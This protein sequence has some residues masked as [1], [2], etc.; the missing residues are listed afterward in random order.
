MQEGGVAYSLDKAEASPHDDAP[1]PN[2]LH[3]H[4]PQKPGMA[5]KLLDAAARNIPQVK[6]C[7]EAGRVMR[8]DLLVAGAAPHLP[9]HKR[10]HASV[11]T[12]SV[13]M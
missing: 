7:G 13:S 4:S 2:L 1:C 11:S 10:G 3:T 8:L 9:P 5:N 12:Q 6:G